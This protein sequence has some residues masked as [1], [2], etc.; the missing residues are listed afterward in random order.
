M[1]SLIRPRARI[2]I[3]S[4][5]KLPFIAPPLLIRNFSSSST[6]NNCLIAP[7]LFLETTQVDTS[8]LTKRSFLTFSPR[9]ASP[10]YFKLPNLPYKSLNSVF[11]V[12]QKMTN[13]LPQAELY[14]AVQSRMAASAAPAE[15]K[16]AAPGKIIN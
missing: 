1:N 6:S 11:T 15:T 2:R 13:S 10:N 5:S 9:Q 4:S 8:S 12:K 7:S 14:T 16:A 3:R